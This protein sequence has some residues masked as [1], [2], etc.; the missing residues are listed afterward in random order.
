MLLGRGDSEGREWSVS[1]C[2]C[3]WQG[4]PSGRNYHYSA[5]TANYPHTRS[6]AVIIKRGALFDWNHFGTNPFLYKFVLDEYGRVYAIKGF[7]FILFFLKK[8]K[9]TREFSAFALSLL[10]LV[11]KERGGGDS[12]P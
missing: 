2:V 11:I 4:A 9:Q 3:V 8:K 12:V 5:I 7:I 1:V 6:T 10:K